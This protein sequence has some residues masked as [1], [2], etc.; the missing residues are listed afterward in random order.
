[1]IGDDY[2]VKFGEI[3]KRVIANSGIQDWDK[4]IVERTEEEKTDMILKRDAQ[5]LMQA[6]QGGSMNQI[7]PE[8]GPQ[9]QQ[10]QQPP[11][12]PAQQAPPNL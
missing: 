3:F 11:A 8:V 7:P 1:M 10:G 6:L 12:Q 4:L 5:M 9:D 2:E